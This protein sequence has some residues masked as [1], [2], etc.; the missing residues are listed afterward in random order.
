MPIMTINTFS[1]KEIDWTLFLISAMVS[2][3]HVHQLLQKI[4]LPVSQNAQPHSIPLPLQ[5]ACRPTAH[6]Q[7]VNIYLPPTLV[8]TNIAPYKIQMFLD[9][10][11]RK[12]CVEIHS[13]KVLFIKYDRLQ[14][15]TLFTFSADCMQFLTNKLFEI[16]V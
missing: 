6:R 15:R 13:F 7:V 8:I 5:A 3:L 16:T 9:R 2:Q 11:Q 12:I 10:L 14:R 1:I 4:Y